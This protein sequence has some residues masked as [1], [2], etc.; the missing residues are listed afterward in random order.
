MIGKIATHVH[1][2]KLECCDWAMSCV[3]LRGLRN[4]FAIIIAQVTSLPLYTCVLKNT[5]SID[6]RNFSVY[7]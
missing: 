2:Y 3:Y 5:F 1:D 4:R 7:I 6:E